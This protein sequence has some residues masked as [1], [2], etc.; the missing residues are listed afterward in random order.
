MGCNNTNLIMS[1]GNKKLFNTDTKYINVRKT[2]KCYQA[3]QKINSYSL[4]FV[5]CAGLSPSKKNKFDDFQLLLV[6]DGT[7]YSSVCPKVW[8]LYLNV[9][10]YKNNKHV[11]KIIADRCNTRINRVYLTQFILK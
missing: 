2:L 8:V 5:N 3:Q 10:R 6:D 4:F 7:Y 9:Y 11:V 1:T